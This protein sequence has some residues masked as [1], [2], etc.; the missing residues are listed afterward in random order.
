MATLCG[1]LALTVALL[2]AASGR[3]AGADGLAAG[4]RAALAA[5]L[6]QVR[7]HLR[8]GI[9]PYWAERSPDSRHGGFLTHLDETGQPTGTTHKWLTMQTRMIWSFAAAHRHGL[10]DRGYLDLAEQGFAFVEEHMRDREHG[11]Y[12]AVVSRS[13]EMLKDHKSTYQQ[14]FAIY[15]FSELFLASGNA[16]ALA[17][18]EALFDV[19]QAK[20]RDGDLGYHEHLAADWSLR[21]GKPLRKTL[22]THMHV[23]E[24]FTTLYEASGKAQH[25]AALEQVVDLLL[26]KA[27]HPQDGY[28]Y[29]PYDR[30]WV[31]QPGR[32]RAMTTMYGHN[33]EL[34]WLLLEAFRVLGRDRDQHRD[35]VLGLID[36]A[37]TFGVDRERGGLALYG[38]QMGDVLDADQLSP[39]RLTK[40][41]WEQAELLVATAEAFEWTHEQR[42]LLGLRSTW[43]W[44][45]KHQ[46]DH[47]HGEWFL[48][49][50]WATGAATNAG[51]GGDYKCAYHN[52][53]ALMRIERCLER[54]LADHPP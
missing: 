38:P 30:D 32:D 48:A 8:E 41:W 40:S 24:C 53:R 19:F 17:S 16:R 35:A 25:R 31:P 39:R 2:T 49:T 42:Y 4:D 50:D 27:I 29:E 47:V 13:G 3:L 36:H 15:A 5:T 14:T 7:D 28:A 43:D 26:A 18:A 11:G 12:F 54:I 1:F 23:M 33:V 52:G 44:T 34:A 46:I 45:W 21:E 6:V 22:D 20:A 37:L 51:K 9:M 10:N